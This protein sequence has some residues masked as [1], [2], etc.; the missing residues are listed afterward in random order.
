VQRNSGRVTDASGVGRLERESCRLDSG[1]NQRRLVLSGK[2]SKLTGVGPAL[3]A[4]GLR[5]LGISL[6]PQLIRASSARVGHID[7]SVEPP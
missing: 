5:Y 1:T 6:S 7:R 3:K 2:V 4:G